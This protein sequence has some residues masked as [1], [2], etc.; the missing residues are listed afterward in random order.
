[1]GS[2][3]EF[4][5]LHLSALAHDVAALEDALLAAGALSVTLGDQQDIAILEP[6]VG[7]TPLWPEVRVSALFDPDADRARIL[8]TLG[9]ALG[10]VPE[11]PLW[12][13][14]AA[15]AWER[16]WLQHF[17]PLR[18][19]ARLWVCPGGATVEQADAVVM[20]LDPG[21]AFGTG[22]HPTTALCLE[23]L[24]GH[25][26]DGRQVIDYGSGSGI[27]GVAALLLGAT[28]VR[29]VDID[30]QALLASRD[31]ATRNGIDAARLET[32]APQA[33]DETGPADVLLAN[34]LAGPLVELAPRFARLLR[35]GA[36]A[37]LS[38][39]LASQAT[40]VLEAY[41][42]WFDVAGTSIRDEWCRLDLVR[43]P[44]NPECGQ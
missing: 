24:A 9:R 31:N 20:H 13:H 16:E 1:M 44:R 43:T 11:T 25:P 19:G 4:L 27:L 6:G 29:A 7:E 28:R 21:L 26:C 32:C 8:E 40:A 10:S 35:T 17:A 15:R 34:I 36:H 38:G 3:G 14:L 30:P 18:F 22:T 5:Q 41:R 2:E 23:W 37:V 12:E 39:V 42:P 33:L